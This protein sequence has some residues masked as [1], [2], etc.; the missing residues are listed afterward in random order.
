MLNHPTLEKLETMKCFGMARAFRDQL[1]MKDVGSLSFEERLGLL[2][3]REMTVRKEKR[4]KIRLSQARLRL[5]ASVEDIDFKKS[6][7]L[8][9]SMI[10]SLGS[11]EWVKNHHNILIAGSTGVGKTYLACAIA[12]KACREGY[13]AVY[14]RV[15][16]LFEE[17]SLARGDGRY[18]KLLLSLSKK[19]LLILDDWGLISL[20]E[21]NRRDFLE[22]LEDRYQRRSTIIASQVPV[23]HWHKLIGDSTIADAILDR[24][25]HNAY[26]IGLGGESMRKQA[27]QLN[28]NRFPET[29]GYDGTPENGSQTK[30]LVKENL[31]GNKRSSRKGDKNS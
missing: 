3:D 6:R 23:D 18:S 25:I 1:E 28:Q 15:P 30:E 8:D 20:T 24:F 31:P 22:I 7:G 21:D 2:V 4:L 11:C 27:S 16:R 10:L 29:K 17:L 19:E 13:S 5:T 26:K 9:R 12:E 14:F